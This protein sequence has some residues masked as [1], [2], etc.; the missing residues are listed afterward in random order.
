MFLVII[1]SSVYEANFTT[2]EN[3][4]WKQE[5]K[6]IGVTHTVPVKQYSVTEAFFIFALLFF[7]Q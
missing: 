1:L 6:T 2:E 5:I 3:I 7:V 4:Q